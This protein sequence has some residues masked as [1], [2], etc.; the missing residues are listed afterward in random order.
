MRRA[1][2]LTVFI[3]LAMA[4]LAQNSAPAPFHFVLLGD[5]TGEPQPG[6]WERVWKD[7]A[8]ENPAFVAGCGDSIEGGDDA[9]A[10]AEWQE[11]EKTLAPYRQIPLYLAPGNHDI[12]SPAS[13]TLFRKYTSHPLHYSFDHG[14]AHFTILDDSRSDSLPAEEFAFLQSDLEQHKSQPVKFVL[15]HRPFWILD[16]PLRNTQADMQQLA[17]KY[18]VKYIIAGHI[19][20]LLHADLEG[21]LYLSLP[22][23]GGHLRASKKYED[24][25]FFGYT[26]V[27]VNG[28]DVRMQIHELGAP[29]GK[30]RSTTPADWGLTGLVA[31]P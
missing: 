9:T 21:I 25:W 26:V 11:V 31:R 3:A 17:R 19:H 24:G 18:G 5:R 8:S 7:I 4:V 22:S 6:I 20:Q 16:A 14:P 27:T 1:W 15:S 2:L 23:A 28:S 12:W 13:E 30:G 10:V 29:F